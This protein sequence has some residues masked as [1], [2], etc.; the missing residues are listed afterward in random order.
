MAIRKS[1]WALGRNLMIVSLI[2]GLSSIMRMSRKYHWAATFFDLANTDQMVWIEHFS[3]SLGIPA[4][5]TGFTSMI[6]SKPS[7]KIVRDEELKSVFTIV[8]IAICVCIIYACGEA[9]HEYMQLTL[10]K[11]SN[12][13]QF[14]KDRCLGINDIKIFGQCS[15]QYYKVVQFQLVADFVGLLTFSTLLIY[16]LFKA[17]R[18]R[19]RFD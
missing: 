13:G 5:F 7:V 1:Y 9:G 8:L 15:Q 11:P 10:A 17:V 19:C 4:F 3:A 18:S 6:V 16:G 14:I 12:F 2:C